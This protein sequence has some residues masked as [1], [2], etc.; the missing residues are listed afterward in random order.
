MI[1]HWEEAQETQRPFSSLSF[2]FWWGRGLNRGR[3]RHV[4]SLH[5]GVVPFIIGTGLNTS[6]NL[7]IPARLATMG[8]LEKAHVQQ[9]PG[10]DN[11]FPIAMHGGFLLNP[12][13]AK[14]LLRNQSSFHLCIVSQPGQLTWS[15]QQMPLWHL[16]PSPCPSLPLSFLHSVNTNEQNSWEEWFHIFLGFLTEKLLGILN[17]LMFSGSHTI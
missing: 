15:H 8:L 7:F 14:P 17:F 9:A 13:Q 2:G 16:S 12:G 3:V 1:S 10:S 11:F 5:Q 6:L 4:S